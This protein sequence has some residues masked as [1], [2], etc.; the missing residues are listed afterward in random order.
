VIMNEDRNMEMQTFAKS[1][2][3]S[4]PMRV[5]RMRFTIHFS[6]SSRDRLR[7]SESALGESNGHA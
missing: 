2:F 4:A 6:P 5:S 1:I 3:A 7:R